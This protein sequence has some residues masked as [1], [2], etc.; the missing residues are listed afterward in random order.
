MTKEK[1]Q[2]FTLRITQANRTQLT[3][4]LY[5]MALYYVDEAQLAGEG[6]PENKEK[7]EAYRTAI[8]KARN[9]VKELQSTLNYDYPISGNLLSLYVYA[10]RELTRADVARKP[11]YLEN[12]KRVLSSLHD[13]FARVSEEDDSEAI[14]ENT[15]T[16]YAGL[17]YGKDSLNE[18]LAD[19]GG[20]RGF[21]V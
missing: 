11:A 15:Q 16:V 3:V 6:L 17:T 1:K 14:M 13:A 21:F 4:I 12:V 20:S 18:N 5:E 19:Q 9:C 10:N 7:K 8:R 2:E